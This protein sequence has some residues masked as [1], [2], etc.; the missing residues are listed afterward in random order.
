M[1]ETSRYV[2]APLPKDTPESNDALRRISVNLQNLST[3][4]EEF[5]EFAMEFF[6]FA[7]YG[8]MRMSASTAFPDLGAAWQD[9]TV[10]DT[11]IVPPRGMTFDPATDRFSFTYPGVYLLA[12]SFTFT[13]DELNA[14][15]ETN[16]RIYD[17]TNASGLASSP[18]GTGRNTHVSSYANTGV[19]LIHQRYGGKRI[20][21]PDRQR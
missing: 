19:L 8:G 11:E 16:T 18:I 4:L 21:Y 14:G 17:H 13:H 15:R 2:F 3:R 10:Y 20:R 12:T 7:A 1:A 5:I 9:V 6:S